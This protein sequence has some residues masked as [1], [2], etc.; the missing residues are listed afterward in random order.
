MSVAARQQSWQANHFNGRVSLPHAVSLISPD[1]A[2]V[3]FIF[4]Y[5][6]DALAELSEWCQESYI[7]I[8]LGLYGQTAMV[9]ISHEIG[10]GSIPGA[11]TLTKS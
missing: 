1:N 10:S 7:N 5:L 9:T 3:L 6:L 2:S 8:C 4:I 11:G